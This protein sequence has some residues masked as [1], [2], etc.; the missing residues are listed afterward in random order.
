MRHGE[1][2][3]KY[4]YMLSL[5]SLLTRKSEQ[6]LSTRHQLG[7]QTESSPWNF[8]RKIAHLSGG[9]KGYWTEWYP[10]HRANSLEEKRPPGMAWTLWPIQPLLLIEWNP[11]SRTLVNIRFLGGGGGEGG[12]VWRTTHI[13]DD[14]DRQLLTGGYLLSFGRKSDSDALCCSS[15]SPNGSDEDRQQFHFSR[16]QWEVSTSSVANTLY[17]WV[18]F[19]GH[20]LFQVDAW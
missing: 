12:E 19:S 13:F 8:R 7:H 18:L 15:H 3:Q 14:L 1:Y 4:I 16:E 5:D 20:F 6:N 10:V 11:G 2:F 9:W 17:L